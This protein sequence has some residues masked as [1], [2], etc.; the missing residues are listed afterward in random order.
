MWK[1]T[2]VDN[3]I[4]QLRFIDRHGLDWPSSKGNHAPTQKYPI[5]LKIVTFWVSCLGT[6]SWFKWK[7]LLNIVA[8]LGFRCK[9]IKNVIDFH[10]FWFVLIRFK[11][12]KN[13]LHRAFKWERGHKFRTD[14]KK[15][16]DFV[17]F[18]LGLSNFWVGAWF[19]FNEGQFKLIVYEV[20][21]LNFD[22]VRVYHAHYVPYYLLRK[23]RNTGSIPFEL[24]PGSKILLSWIRI[25]TEILD[26][27]GI[28]VWSWSPTDIFRRVTIQDRNW[29]IGPLISDMDYSICFFILLWK[30][31]NFNSQRH[32]GVIVNI[33]DKS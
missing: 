16:L 32:S 26:Q 15:I 7:I 18:P 23:S 28:T 2:D 29:S 21:W 30:C 9:T 25:I 17:F 5:W 27:C 6:L 3:I 10:L 33:I 22:N 13:S 24:E 31:Q 14:F 8:F 19:P 20:L 11:S 1:S 12:S 4:D